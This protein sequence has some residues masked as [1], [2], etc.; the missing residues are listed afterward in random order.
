MA[1][2]D[3]EDVDPNLYT[4]RASDT[5]AH[6]AVKFGLTVPELRALNRLTAPAI[7]PGQVI[8]VRGNAPEQPGTVVQEE[9]KSLRMR[10]DPSAL[11]MLGQDEAVRRVGKSTF[12]RPSDETPMNVA[13][14]QAANSDLS[15][16]HIDFEEFCNASMCVIRAMYVTELK[17]VVPGILEVTR[18]YVRFEPDNVPLVREQGP[19]EFSLYFEFMDLLP[20]LTQDEAPEF[21]RGGVLE[22]PGAHHRVAPES[23]DPSAPVYP[24]YMQ[25]RVRLV[26]GQTP[27]PETIQGYW[28]AILP[29]WIDQV[30]KLVWDNTTLDVESWQF[31]D[32]T[33]VNPLLA[34]FAPYVP[35]LMGRTDLLLAEELPKF[36]DIL[37]RQHQHSDWIL[38][39]SSYQHGISLATFYR[40]MAEVTS[41]TIMIIRDTKG[42]MFGCYA[43]HPWECSDKY[44]GSGECFVFKL[45]PELRTYLWTGKNPYF[46]M[47]KRDSIVVG[48]GDGNPALWLDEDFNHGTSATSLTFGNDVLASSSDFQIDGLEVWGFQAADI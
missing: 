8:R 35:K 33:E 25:L 39:Y 32:K 6:V 13:P 15:S 48:G 46:L 5:L 20:P 26:F 12:F 38:A 27:T 7:F 28:F 19:A 17:G 42:C 21:N 34:V 18:D 40:K 1:A 44:F 37:P 36:R 43:S 9:P 31:V 41:A 4:V 45:R 22:A 47:G 23:H 30:F 24:K 14:P 11:G 29:K 3:D 16:F 2:V 10:M